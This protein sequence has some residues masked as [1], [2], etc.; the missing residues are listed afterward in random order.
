MEAR[1][2]RIVLTV[3]DRG[4]TFRLLEAN[5]INFVSR[6]KK[7]RGLA[8]LLYTMKSIKTIYDVCKDT[9]IDL[10][11]DI[12]SIYSAPLSNIFGK[13]YVVFDDTEG[14]TKA[15]FI[16]MPFTNHI[17]TPY[18]F[19]KNLGAK[20]LRFDG[21]LELCYL[22]PNY[23]KPDPSILK[24]LGVT[25][26]ERYVII[27]FVAWDAHHDIGKKGLSL[28][29]KKELVEK[30]SKYA[31]VFI[32]S[33]ADPPKDLEQYMITIPPEKMHNALSYASLYIG[34]GAT[35]AS[36]SACVGTPA[37]F[38]NSSEVGYCTEQ[39]DRY[40]LVYNFREPAGV[41]EKALELIQLPEIKEEFNRRRQKLLS[42]KIDVTAFMVWF[43]ENYPESA[44]IMNEHPEYQWKFG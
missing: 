27:R 4:C 20:Q 16:H 5:N 36:E 18:C 17:L 11:L 32:S 33:E 24:I 31:R 15:R 38:V 13:P 1:N 8:F 9:N 23:F 34:E 37:I 40:G 22:H 14:S 28:H 35:M 42:E 30:I 26:N 3:R 12:G 39:E 41:V 19:H 29:Q 21:Y 10:F 44:M 7:R 6:G 43:A 25:E 2:H